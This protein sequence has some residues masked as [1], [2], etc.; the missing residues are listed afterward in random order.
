MTINEKFE[1][2]IKVL[3]NGNK[4]AFAQTVGVSPTV[5]E[6]VVGSRKGKPSYDVLKKVCSNANISADWLLFGTNEDHISKVFAI[7]KNL[8]ITAAPSDAPE[9]KNKA[10]TTTFTKGEEG[11][12]IEKEFYFAKGI[13]L[14]SP[15]DLLVISEENDALY[16]NE[17][18]RYTIPEFESKM[19]DFLI[20][21][22]GDT[23][24]PHY[25]SGDIV[26]CKILSLSDMFFQ[27]GKTYILGTE[28]GVLIKKVEQG[29]TDEC[30]TLVSEDERYKPFEVSKHNIYHISIVLGSI[31][32]E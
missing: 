2:I 31:R 10:I 4:R 6:N 11:I 25:N 7:R 12:P 13:P 20:R 18:E 28:Q 5:V 15:H 23:M 17:Y 29:A 1:V 3:F 24:Q 14:I 26:A 21:I 22:S 27:W 19:A 9:D 8:T 32:L 30:I 16:L